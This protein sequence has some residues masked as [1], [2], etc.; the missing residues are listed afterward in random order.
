MSIWKLL[1][2]RPNI[3]RR[4]HEQIGKLTPE[5]AERITREFG[6]FLAEQQPIIKDAGLLPYSKAFIMKALIMQEQFACDNANMLAAPGRS[7]ELQQIKRY[8][9]SLGFSRMGLCAYSDIDSEDKE[10]VSYFNSF[11]ALRDVPEDRKVE[12]VKLVAKY[13][14]RGMESEIP[15]WNNMGKSPEKEKQG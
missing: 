10:A 13:M 6:R 15:G 11:R 14:S 1:K 12:C 3:S 8:I 9:G 7:D 5:D 2:R 4:S